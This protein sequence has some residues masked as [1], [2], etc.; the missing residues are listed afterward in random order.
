MSWMPRAIRNSQSTSVCKALA[1]QT[2]I[3]IYLIK[4]E[5]QLWKH[6]LVFS[7][8]PSSLP[9]SLEHQSWYEFFKQLG[10]QLEL[11]SWNIKWCSIIPL[12]L[13][14]LSLLR[15]QDLVSTLRKRI[16]ILFKGQW[17]TENCHLWIFRMA[18]RNFLGICQNTPWNDCWRG[19]DIRL[20]LPSGLSSGT[21]RW[22]NAEFSIYHFI[23][24][25]V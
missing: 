8:P 5:L 15:H 1:S 7:V 10:I 23:H 9:T 6:T 22:V 11:R 20:A 25:W 14:F 13:V 18:W 24:L 2:L 17:N 19:P 3:F 16:C 12:V 4:R 21:T